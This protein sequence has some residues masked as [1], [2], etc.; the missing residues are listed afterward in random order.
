MSSS[1]DLVQASTSMMDLEADDL[2]HNLVFSTCRESGDHGPFNSWDRQPYLTTVRT[3]EPSMT[4]AWREL[5]HNFFIDNYS[6]QENVDNDDGSEYYHTHD[7]FLVYGN[8]GEK[9]DFGVTTT[10]T[11]V[12]FMHM[13][14]RLS[15]SRAHSRGTRA[16][17]TETRLC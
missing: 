2:S 1:T 8:N 13:R 12:T 11:S 17:S 9:T 14:A 4:M 6:P 7:N 15:P 3:G 5:H 16:I 10:I